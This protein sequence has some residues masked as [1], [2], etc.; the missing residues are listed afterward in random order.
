MLGSKSQAASTVSA[1]V[2]SGAVL[3]G[4]ERFN[5][6][7]ALIVGAP[8]AVTPGEMAGLGAIVPEYPNKAFATRGLGAIVMQRLNGNQQNQGADIQ[9][10]GVVNTNAFG[11]RV[12]G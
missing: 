4:M 7:K 2:I 11:S 3:W 10:R 9:L 5:A 12:A 6:N 8:V 1:S